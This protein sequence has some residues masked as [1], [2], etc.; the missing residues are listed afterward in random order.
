M[1]QSSFLS[2]DLILSYSVLKHQRYQCS[3]YSS[4]EFLDSD[5]VMQMIMRISHPTTGGKHLLTSVM[6]GSALVS[7]H[8]GN[9]FLGRVQKLAR[10]MRWTACSVIP[11]VYEA[12][13]N[14]PSRQFPEAS[15]LVFFCGQ[16][17]RTWDTPLAV[18]G[19]CRYV[20]VLKMFLGFLVI[21][22]RL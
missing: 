6:N 13:F 9:E 14:D 11:Q 20:I 7:P 12:C 21:E 17:L 5:L 10:F 8:V 2:T 4:I 15:T 1:S 22:P 19:D 3:Y 16:R 18:V